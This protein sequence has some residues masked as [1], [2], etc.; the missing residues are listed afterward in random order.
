MTVTK[1]RFMNIHILLTCTNNI[2]DR[3]AFTMSNNRSVTKIPMMS[4]HMV[5]VYLKFNRISFIPDGVFQH[6][7]HCKMIDLERNQIK[8]IQ[9]GAFNGLPE[10]DILFLKNNHIDYI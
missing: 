3:K 5:F 7:Y 6:L 9:G 10:L 4:K 8:R 1:I 2:Y